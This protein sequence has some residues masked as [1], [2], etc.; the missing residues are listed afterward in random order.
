VRVN[1]GAIPSALVESEMFGREKGAYTGALTKQI[2]RFEL[3]NGSTIFLDEI[4]ELPVE[5]QVKLLRA[6]QEKEIERLGNPKPIKVDV[7]II[8]ATNENLEKAVAGGKFREDLYYRLNVFPI[9]IP[10]LRERRE[11]I[12]MLTWA[13]VDTLSSEFGKK[14]ESISRKSIEALVEYSWPGNVRELRNTIERAMILHPSNSPTL[15]IELAKSR[16]AVAGQESITLKEIEIRHICKVLENTGWKIRGKLGAAEILGMKPT[17]LETRMS[18]LG[19][20]RPKDGA[21]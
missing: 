1:C 15:N 9:E 10:P 6:L 20:F 19:I 7:R 4:T 16:Q 14:V 13:F 3:A 11:D 5:V 2:G 12:P 18:R 8:T 21:G 17:T